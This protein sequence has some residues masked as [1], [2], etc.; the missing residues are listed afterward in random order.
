MLFFLPQDVLTHKS[1]VI[2]V[3]AG[4]EEENLPSVLHAAQ[5]GLDRVGAGLQVPARVPLHAGEICPGILCTDKHARFEKGPET[6][7]PSL[8]RTICLLSVS[9]FVIVLHFVTSININVRV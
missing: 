3:R 4:D 1:A 9:N 2:A 7:P 8:K 5:P 6:L